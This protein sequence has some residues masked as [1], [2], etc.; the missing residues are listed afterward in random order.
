MSR[1]LFVT[2][3][4]IC[5]GAEKHLIQLVLRLADHE[6]ECVILC[7]ESDVFTKHLTGSSHIQ[8][9]SLD[10]SS[11]SFWFLERTFSR[12]RPHVIVFNNI[13]LGLFPWYVYLA[14]RLSAIWRVFLIEHS[15]GAAPPPLIA[16]KGVLNALRRCCGWRARFVWRL[17]LPS[18]LSDGTICVSNSIRKRLIDDYGY[19]PAKTVTILNGVDLRWYAPSGDATQKGQTT[20]D[21]NRSDGVLLCVANL[22]WVKKIDV[23]LE[24]VRLV[25]KSRSSCRCII[26]GG[27]DLENTLRA[28][29][30]ELGLAKTVQFVGYVED[31]R[32][33][34]EQADVFVLSSENEGLPLVLGEAMA[35]GIP[36]IATDVGGNKEIVSHGQTG[37]LVKPGS[38]EQ[39][40]EAIEYLLAHPDE[41]SRMGANALR[42]VHEHFNIEDS[43]RRLKCVLLGETLSDLGSPAK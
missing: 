21:P 23:L 19:S 12:L 31:V 18:L 37:L 4:P 35:Y 28:Q 8:V 26:V 14:A 11:P 41:R 42:R 38:P 5:G 16:G 13:W 32:S 3:T 20:G 6:T 22:T 7:F 9:I 24:A 29:S 15:T 1:I 40:A 43:M 30:I 27:G 39:L 33:Y 36:C 2:K 34:F 25:A 10:R 17:R